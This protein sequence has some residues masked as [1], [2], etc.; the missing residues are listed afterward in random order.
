[1]KTKQCFKTNYLRNEKFTNPIVEDLPY[2][3]SGNLGFLENMQVQK[4]MPLA[5]PAKKN[6][7]AVVITESYGKQFKHW[8]LG[9]RPAA[10]I[11]TLALQKVRKYFIS[12]AF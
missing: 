9:L 4:Q 1:L 5:G 8:E 7:K 12:T 6:N 10:Q 2:F 11:P 3:P